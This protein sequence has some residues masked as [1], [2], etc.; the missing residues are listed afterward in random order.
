MA[1]RFTEHQ[2]AD[3]WQLFG[4]QDLLPIG[5]ASP[6][7][8]PSQQG[9]EGGRGIHQHR[10]REI[11]GRGQLLDRELVLPTEKV[12]T[13]GRDGDKGRQGVD[14]VK[15]GGLDDPGER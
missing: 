15:S 14:V 2:F 13:C 7:P 4:S 1:A 9:A 8:G 3:P 6:A 11:R 12:P 5:P 10:P